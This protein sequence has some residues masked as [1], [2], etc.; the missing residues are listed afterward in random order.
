MVKERKRRTYREI[1]LD[2]LTELSNGEQK[3]ISNSVLREELGWDEEGYNQLKSELKN[4]KKIMVGQGR[5]GTVALAK[6]PGVKGLSVFISYAHSDEGVK[7]EL[8]KHLRPLERL[9]LISEWHDRKLKAGEEWDRVISENLRTS[10]IVL[11]LISVDF[12]NSRYCFDVELEEAMKMHDAKRT[13]VIPVVV[14]NCL[15]SPMPFAKLQALPRDGKA[16]GSWSDRDEA[17]TNVAEGVRTV[18]DELMEER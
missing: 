7:N 3:L 12:I 15:W 8:V 16:V 11:L 2:K 4:E 9:G 5:G 10:D 14:R 18:A 6:A 1:F 13:R 17:L